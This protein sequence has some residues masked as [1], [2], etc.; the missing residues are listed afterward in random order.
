L[1][2]PQKHFPCCVPVSLGGNACDHCGG[3]GPVTIVVALR[4]TACVTVGAGGRGMGG[5]GRPRSRRPNTAAATAVEAAATVSSP[6]SPSSIRPPDGLSPPIPTVFRLLSLSN[7]VHRGCR[8]HHCHHQYRRH[9]NV[10]S[11]KLY[12]E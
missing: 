9:R 6:P 3:P 2:L 8:R 5:G 7:T 11:P 12:P 10:R 4:G 1:T